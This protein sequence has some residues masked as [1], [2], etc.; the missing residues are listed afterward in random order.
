MKVQCR[1][2]VL[3]VLALMSQACTFNNNLHEGDYV[4]QQRTVKPVTKT[5][6]TGF[7]VTCT[8]FAKHYDQVI[9]S[10][11]CNALLLTSILDVSVQEEVLDQ[12]TRMHFENPLPTV[13]TERP[14]M[15]GFSKVVHLD[16][17]EQYSWP[18]LGFQALVSTLTLTLIPLNYPRDYTITLSIE[19]ADGLVE[20][21]ASRQVV[22]D[23][24]W[25]MPLMFSYPFYNEKRASENILLHVGRDLVRQLESP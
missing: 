19:N 18:R 16:I 20:K 23:N 21:S 8:S 15:D 22:M 2:F 11:P 10:S 14:V 5:P 12:F 7:Y 13:M 9:K 25:W 6:K 24:W 3:L 1:W 4:Q 17:H